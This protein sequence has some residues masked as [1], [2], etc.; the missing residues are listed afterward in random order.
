[1]P[2]RFEFTKIALSMLKAS[3]SILK[4]STEFYNLGHPLLHAN[5]SMPKLFKLLR[6]LL[7][8][9]QSPKLLRFSG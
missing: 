1:M 9:L 4:N 3:A 6:R 5:L 2:M 8:S 7:S